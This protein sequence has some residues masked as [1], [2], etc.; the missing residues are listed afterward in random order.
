MKK[1][2]LMILFIGLAVNAATAQTDAS[3]I[4]LN[5]QPQCLFNEV[6]NKTDIGY[7]DLVNAYRTNGVMQDAQAKNHSTCL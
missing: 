7:L 2:T 5:G 6:L 4:Q 1:L 3:T